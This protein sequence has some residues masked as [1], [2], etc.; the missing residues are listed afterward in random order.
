MLRHLVDWG[1]CS[2]VLC[3]ATQPAW[4]RSDFLPCGFEN[5]REI[6]PPELNLFERLRRVRVAWPTSPD[7]RWD[8]D[9]VAELMRRERAA[10]CIVNTRR[11]AR[12]LFHKLRET[13]AKGLFHLSTAMCPAHRLAVLDEVR[14]RLAAG[15]TCRLVSTQLIEA[16]CDVDFP[17]V[18]REMAPLEAVIQ[19][20]GRCNREGLLNGPDGAPGGKVVVFRSPQGT[21]PPDQWY[22]LGVAKLEQDFLALG[23][24]PDIGSTQD[25]LDYFQRL[26]R[27]GDLDR[28]GITE[29]RLQRRFAT[30]A[31]KFRLIGDDTT[32]V[33]V[34]TWEPF[35]SEVD[36]LL[37]AVRHHP[38]KA[39]YRR[40]AQYQINLRHY[41]L[42]AAGG[43]VQLDPS[44]VRVWLGGYDPDLG[45][46][47]DKLRGHPDRV[48]QTTEG[49]TTWRNHS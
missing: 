33:V 45:L 13:G 16:G 1:G 12:E 15:K 42:L 3:T 8:W 18:L 11:A 25:I 9:R 39:N 6:V 31:S 29:D 26:Y 47:P 4:N 7:E 36:R 40:L 37:A 41:E 22:K 28:E 14:R 19:S 44:G 2:V 34:K 32:A 46:M 27:S 48:I 30:A 21:L 5:V 38:S 35:A 49:T 10:L 43:S 24:Q 20:A 23:R 17:L